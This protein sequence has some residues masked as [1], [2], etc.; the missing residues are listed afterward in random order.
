MIAC[1]PNY[2]P[3]CGGDLGSVE[4]EDR[5]RDYCPSCDRI[6]WRQS[7]PTTS[8]TVREDDRVL[9]IQRSSG[10]DAGRWDVPA[11]HPEFDEPAREAAARELREETSLVVDPANLEL[12]GT[13]L[14]E[15]PRAVY[16]SINYRVNRTVTDGAV[17]SGSDAADARF[18]SVESLRAGEVDVRGLGRRRLRNAGVLE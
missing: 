1:E 10:R 5:A 16:R 15:G 3:E 6:W 18:A 13:V 4:F 9:L 12:V 8:V 17:R 14:S 2:C 7:V 11:G